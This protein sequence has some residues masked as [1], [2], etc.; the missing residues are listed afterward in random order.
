MTREVGIRQLKN[1]ASALIGEV[2]RGEI[3]TVTRRGKPVARVIPA[4][5]SPGMAKLVEAGRV[6]WNGRKPKPAVPAPM[7]GDGPTAAE[8]VDEGRG[9]R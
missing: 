6:R 3:I 5:V 4:G 7:R 1:E 8:I 2:E 9:P